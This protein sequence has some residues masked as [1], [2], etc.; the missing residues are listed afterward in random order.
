MASLTKPPSIFF[1]STLLIIFTSSSTLSSSA[2]TPS[3]WPPQFH[4]VLFMNFTGTLQMIDLWYDWPNG[5]NFNIIRSQLGG[6]LYDLEWNNGT[7][8]FYSFEG[9]KECRSVQL[10]VGILRPNWL[11]GAEHLGQRHLNGF[12]CNVW[13]KVGFLWYYEDVVTR[14]P[15]CWVF[16]SV[17][18]DEK[19]QAP[20]YCFS[21]QQNSEELKPEQPNFIKGAFEKR[22][23]DG[24]PSTFL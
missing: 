12:V 4:A 7:S 2:P 6:L 9:K 5:R 11:E 1:F 24:A 15:V 13:Q 16:Y 22:L 20:V 14:R 21:K 18:D 10:E 23:I 8:F 17:L 19:W 3:P